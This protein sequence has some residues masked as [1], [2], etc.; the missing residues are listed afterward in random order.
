MKCVTTGIWWHFYQG[1]ISK[2]SW[3]MLK[4]NRGKGKAQ[5]RFCIRWLWR[6]WEL[7]NNSGH[8]MK[9]KLG[10]TESQKEQERD[11]G[12]TLHM[13][14][15]TIFRNN[16]W[17]EISSFYCYLLVMRQASLILDLNPLKSKSLDL[18]G[19]KKILLTE[20]FFIPI[21]TLIN[22]LALSNNQCGKKFLQQQAF[23]WF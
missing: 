22:E 7:H 3:A 20:V 15:R 4:G 14:L 17:M 18:N 5:V 2:V 16:R 11:G 1:K 19:F 13:V 8:L 12:E 21:E 9:W 10:S 23:V 6:V